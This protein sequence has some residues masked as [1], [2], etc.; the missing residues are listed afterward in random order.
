MG[1]KWIAGAAFGWS[2]FWF[3]VFVI[4]TIWNLIAPWPTS[5]WSSYWHVVGIGI[6]ILLSLI[7]GIW[8]SWGGIRDMRD[9]F[10]RLKSRRINERDD[11][12]VVNH[13]NLDE[14]NIPVK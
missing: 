10:H 8:F 1:A 5:V 13:Q 6:P 14:E 12:T 3:V 4:G 11:G 7:T 9:L 2:I